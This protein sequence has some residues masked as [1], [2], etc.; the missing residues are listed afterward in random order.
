M[1]DDKKDAYFRLRDRICDLSVIIEDA[2]AL[3]V[4]GGTHDV[5]KEAESTLELLYRRRVNLATAVAEFE[6]GHPQW[7]KE[8]EV[9]R[10]K[11]KIHT[12][13]KDTFINFPTS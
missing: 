10:K 4:S 11:D 3:R 5:M 1:S 6:H 2:K 8:W 9:S 13:R 12:R 7:V